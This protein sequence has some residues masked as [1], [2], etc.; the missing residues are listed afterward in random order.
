M[1][2]EP[3]DAVESHVKQLLIAVK[4]KHNPYD[5]TQD[6]QSTSFF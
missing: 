6:G 1:S 3:G 5:D 4:H 2:E